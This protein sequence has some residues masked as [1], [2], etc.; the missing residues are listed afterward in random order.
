MF[1][2]IMLVIWLWCCAVVMLRIEQ[3]ETRVPHY[4]IQPSQQLRTS[5]LGDRIDKPVVFYTRG[6][7]PLLVTH[8]RGGVSGHGQLRDF[9][10][11][12]ERDRARV[13]WRRFPRTADAVVRAERD[14]SASVVA[15][16]FVELREQFAVAWYQA[17]LPVPAD[18]EVNDAQP[19]TAEARAYQ[20]VRGKGDGRTIDA[21]VPRS[22]REGS[23]AI[24]TFS[25]L[26]L[27]M[28]ALA[29]LSC[30]AFVLF[31]VAMQA[32]P[33]V[34]AP[35]NGLEVVGAELHLP[36]HRR[37]ALGIATRW[38]DHAIA[39]VSTT[40]LVGEYEQG[41][42]L[43]TSPL[44]IRP[45]SLQ[46]VR[47]S[48]ERRRLRGAGVL[49][50]WCTLAAL[51]G[52][53]AY[54]PAARALAACSALRCPVPHLA[55][56]M[57]L[58][59]GA[60][61]R[62]QI[63]VFSTR[64]MVDR[65]TDLP[66]LATGPAVA[67]RRMQSHAHALMERL[68]AAGDDESNYWADVIRP[69]ELQDVPADLLE[70]LPSFEDPRLD[71]LL[72]TPPYVPPFKPRLLPKPLQPLIHQGHCPRHP[73]DLMPEVTARRARSWMGRT[74]ADLVCMR[75]FGVDCER[76]SP[77]KLIIGQSELYEWARGGVWDFRRS[78]QECATMLDYGLPLQPTLK[79]DFF[80]REL[81]D[82]PNQQILGM[83]QTGVIYQADV[84]L[85]GVFIPHLTSLPKGYKAVAKELKRLGELKWYEAYPIW[86]FF[87][88]YYN[89]QGSTARKLEPD[90]DRRTTEGGAPRRETWDRSGLKVLSINDASRAYHVPQHYLQDARPEMLT[91]MASRGLPPTEEQLRDLAA[92][93]GSKHGKQY[94][95]TVRT[96]MHDLSCLGRFAVRLNMPIYIFGNDVKDYFN[97]LENAIS[98]LPLMNI[99]WLD[100]DELGSEAKK[101]AFSDGN[102]NRLVYISERRMGFGIHPNSGIAQELSESIDSI[103]RK[104]MDA[105]ADAALEAST[106][107]EVHAWLVERRALEAQH[108]GHQRRLY[109]AHTYCDDNIVI[110]VGI[111]NALAAINIR[112]EIEREAGLIMAIPE[113]RM[114]GTWGIWLGIYIFAGLGLVVIPRSKLLRASDATRRTLSKALPFDE[115]QSLMGLLE[116]IRHAACWPRSIMHGLYR[117]HGPEGESR[118][119]PATLVI[120]T[121]LMAQQ[122][123]RWLLRLGTTAGAVVTDA[124]RRSSVARWRPSVLYVGSSD[125]ATDSDPPGMG[126]FL[127]GFYWYLALSALHIRWLH[128]S[129]LE[130]LASGFSTMIFRRIL[131]PKAELVLGA[132]ASATV[133]SLVLHSQSSEALI[134]AH[135]TLLA[136]PTF[137]D[138]Q[139]HTSLGQLRGD[140]NE[141]GD[142]VSRGKWDTFFSLCKRVRVRPQQMHL[143]AECHQIL[144]KILR[145]SIL[146][147]LPVRS[148]P[149]LASS[150]IIPSTHTHLLPTTADAPVARARL[151]E[152][153]ERHVGRKRRQCEDADGPSTVT[154]A[155]Y[156]D[157][158]YPALQS[159]ERG[160][161]VRA[162]P[163]DH[164][165]VLCLRR[166]YA[167]I[168]TGGAKTPTFKALE[169]VLALRLWP[170][171][172]LRHE[173]AWTTFDASHSNFKA[174]K[175]KL[176][177]LEAVLGLGRPFY[178]PADTVDIMAWSMV[179]D[180]QL[181]PLDGAA[182]AAL[183][184][185][186]AEEDQ[187]GQALNAAFG[188]ASSMLHVEEGSTPPMYTHMMWRTPAE[189][190][191]ID[192]VAIG[193]L[194]FRCQSSEPFTA[195][196]PCA[197]QSL[198]ELRLRQHLRSE[199]MAQ[200]SE[201]HAGPGAAAASMD[202]LTSQT[203]MDAH[204]TSMGRHNLNMTGDMP[205]AHPVGPKRP[206]TPTRED[207]SPAALMLTEMQRL[208]IMRRTE[209]VAYISG[210]SRQTAV[211]DR[212][213]ARARTQAKIHS[214]HKLVQEERLLSANE[215]H[216]DKAHSDCSMGDGPGY[217]AAKALAKTRPTRPAVASHP[218]RY[219]LARHVAPLQ[220]PPPA[221]E[222]PERTAAAMSR[223]GTRTASRKTTSNKL[224]PTVVIDGQAFAAPVERKARA[225]SKRKLAMLALA[226][227][228]ARRMSSPSATTAQV[229]SLQHA[230]RA[231]HELAEHGAAFGT[232]D[233]DDHAYVFWEKFCSLYDWSPTF[234]GD[235]NWARTHPDE[236]SQ[237]LAIFQ[238][239][240]YPQLSGRGERSDAKPRTVFN[241]YVLAVMRTLAREHMP[242]P[243]AKHVEKNLAGLMRSFKNIYGVEHLMPGRKQPLT[244]DMWAR[245]EHLEDGTPLQG[246]L[247][248]SPATRHRDRIIL[249]LGRT[250]WR[251]G[252][253]LGEVV[254]HPSGEI[255]FLTRS[256][257]SIAK[258]SGRKIAVPSAHDW[259]ELTQGDSVLLA[260]CASKSD[261]FGEEHCPFPSILPCDG[262]P[263]AAAMSIRDIELEQPCSPE[264]RKST[265]L[266]G[267][268]NGAP[269]TYAVLHAEL[270][271]LLAAL[272]GERAATAFSWHSIRIG[273]ACALHAANCPD[274]VIQLICRWAN[275]ASLRVYRQLG[276]E[277]HV[278]WTERAQQVTF[279]ATRVNNL[280]VLDSNEALLRNIQ[281][282][283]EPRTVPRAPRVQ[284]RSAVVEPP[285]TYVIPGGTVQTT[286]SDNNNLVGL[287]ANVF[288][289][290]WPGYEGTYGR[291]WCPVVARC[292]REFRHPDGVRC[293]TY[294]IE[295]N[296]AYYPIKHDALLV[297]LSQQIRLTLPVQRS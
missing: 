228:R 154:V 173:D 114:L 73:L 213:Q 68:R 85:Q 218:S 151:L 214:L 143:T 260:P 184:M 80:A 53:V 12:E 15:P 295:Y 219:W 86:P 247:P 178:T 52:T 28:V 20:F 241:N 252:H 215:T 207:R 164:A 186:S 251:T 141:A 199:N 267:D 13:D 249:R 100:S 231:T 285:V 30:N 200:F 225:T 135:Q 274:A 37:L 276:L 205:I 284:A 119:G 64:P 35:L 42:R 163:G 88:G 97:H 172:Y 179:V 237:R 136:S 262:S 240:V 74:L 4:S 256:C 166:L 112:A 40:F 79:A 212:A 55:D 120:P 263:T 236:I 50:G 152:P 1:W 128:I 203:C 117:P 121:L 146:R 2:G 57:A 192:E 111:D 264:A 10:D 279:D 3:P 195:I 108:G 234:N 211:E 182:N 51:A 259:R 125:A 216:R 292:L 191:Q 255:N 193:E 261:Q 62:F 268:E 170:H 101:H 217:A 155:Q 254:W 67:M 209:W 174:Y 56:A 171:R 75:D 250:L 44:D 286:A 102:G 103:F 229:E 165:H 140:A 290:L 246:R 94:M 69:E 131:P 235:A 58:G 183:S 239:W 293:L 149:Y 270:R 201:A 98:E 280:P 118:R 90:R 169:T 271:K 127:H 222:L 65:L 148:N 223:L 167:C 132:D 99:A 32:T 78:P 54:D 22:L 168:G 41:A 81:V 277:K 104:R 238:A 288:D 198:N 116:H 226:D 266:F 49:F 144:D 224:M 147:N 96:I 245:I 66:T 206:E 39:A 227:S 109:A 21:V 197:A 83:I 177:S 278:Y 297:C 232:L 242:M 257:V 77:G 27:Q 126:G 265:P 289:N 220:A 145:N 243:K 248:W 190:F 7:V 281:E 176:E 269:F 196:H 70:N 60:L 142:S 187:P 253:R 72:L 138:A 59:H 26:Q 106:S 34:F 43:F 71:H 189:A 133:T 91:W 113:K 188:D 19:T 122:L 31:F 181:K 89:G 157:A 159:V 38:A 160:R 25:D 156:L 115:Y 230:V 36:T 287:R 272:F 296:G 204:D 153:N 11:D 210:D 134:D 6:L 24:T 16:S 92:G 61:P 124:I 110:I 14:F 244:P 63:G 47:S 95:P 48:A 137:C 23:A 194:T 45:P 123:N 180:D 93:H 139:R 130:L 33:L 208:E 87:P 283:E 76:D 107:P 158:Y 9:A 82:Y 282:F 150:P 46:I 233:I 291:T 17:G 294:L 275:P 84:E 202:G 258:A 185:P 161:S 162:N 175:K 129:V 18:Y 5:M 221:P 105:F 273:L 8:D 29:N